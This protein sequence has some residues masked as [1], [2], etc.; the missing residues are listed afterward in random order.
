[1]H[2]DDLLRTQNIQHSRLTY[3]PRANRNDIVASWLHEKSRLKTN[4]VE[5]QNLL[6]STQGVFSLRLYQDGPCQCWSPYQLLQA[7]FQGVEEGWWWTTAIMLWSR[8]W[9]ASTG[10]WG[11]VTTL[12]LGL[13]FIGAWCVPC[14]ILLHWLPLLVIVRCSCS[15]VG[16]PLFRSLLL[17]T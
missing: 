11:R 2:S 3:I 1:M 4:W 14:F 6:L 15:P 5:E 12:S 17:L 13:L 16:S 9:G 7:L 8:I 10:A